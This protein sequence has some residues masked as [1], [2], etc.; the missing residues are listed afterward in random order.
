[1]KKVIGSAVLALIMTFPG[2]VLPQDREEQGP[3]LSSLIREALENSPRIEAALGQYQAAERRISQAG[4]L[5][6]P[7]ITLGLMNLPVNS[8][9]FDQ[10][11]MTGKL[12]GIMQMFPFPGKQALSTSLART[13]A[14]GLKHMEQE[15]R[16]QTVQA[17]KNV[18]YDIFAVDR[19]RETT[20]R[21]LELMRQFVRITETRYATGAGLQ[22]DVLRAQVEMSR[23]EDGLLV[24]D[25]KRR[26]LEA[27]LNALLNRPAGSGF[28]TTPADLKLPGSEPP[29]I[30]GDE[31][32]QAR[33]LI[34]AWRDRLER[35]GVAV[36]FA[37][38]ERWPNF[39]VGA[40]YAQ[41]DNLLSGA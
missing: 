17:V 24:W 15:V 3:L 18:Y 31:A 6:D 10:E 21:N 4:A 33:P 1:M 26:V 16:N 39:T 11:P 37:E 5:P 28:E 23:I 19:A 34:L 40:S 12:I 41:R 9:A 32:A 27:R 22:Q 29:R 36:K 38:R 30:A 14:S 25:Q 13:E 7:Q 35:A 20:K 8:F 2:T